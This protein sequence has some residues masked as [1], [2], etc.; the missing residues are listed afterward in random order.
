MSVRKP[1]TRVFLSTSSRDKKS[2]FKR[3]RRPALFRSKS[4]PAFPRTCSEASNVKE[5]TSCISNISIPSMPFVSQSTGLLAKHTEGPIHLSCMII[6]RRWPDRC[7]GSSHAGYGKLPSWR[8]N[9]LGCECP[10]AERYCVGLTARQH[11]RR[12]K[13]RFRRALLC[14]RPGPLAR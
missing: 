5:V 2:N 7:R 12:E 13:V 10:T 3:Q 4:D 9:E 11:H 1:R 8:V 6:R 14:P